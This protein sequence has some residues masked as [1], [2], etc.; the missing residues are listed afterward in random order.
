[1][2]HQSKKIYIPCLTGGEPLL[3][4]SFFR[5][6]EEIVNLGFPWGM[7]TNATL[8]DQKTTIK[9]KK[10][11]LSSITISLDG[12]KESHEKLRNNN[13]CFEKTIKAVQFLNESLI[14]VQITTVVHKKNL[15]E[16]EQ[17]YTYVCGLNICSWRIINLEPIGR[18]IKNNDLLLD[19]N[20]FL[21]L[22]D[23]IR[24]KRY[25]RETPMDVRFGCAHY[26]SFEYEHEVRDNYFICGSG[27]YVG[28]ILCDG[29]IFSCL[30]IDRRK[31]L[32]QGN[33]KTDRF[34]DVW[35]NKFQIFRTDRSEESEECSQ[36]K[37]RVFCHADATHTWNFETKTPNFCLLRKENLYGSFT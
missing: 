36:C 3:H 31:E 17:I 21:Y 37:E 19:K 28:S 8:I 22:L 29:D 15:S 9:L 6:V 13:G 34:S 2:Y 20:D 11:G 35:K 4:P 18:A 1:M 5:I 26:L 24:A 27:I 23:F 14:P 32:V 10:Y 30:D 25:S 33:I 7:T 16:L 12:L